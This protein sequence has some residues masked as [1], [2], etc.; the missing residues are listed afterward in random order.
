MILHV[1]NLNI[2]LKGIYNMAKFMPVN[3][4]Q[5]AA[6]NEK[7]S[8]TMFR[9]AADFVNFYNSGLINKNHDDIAKTANEI[10]KTFKNVKDKN[11][12]LV[13]ISEQEV[14]LDEINNNLAEWSLLTKIKREVEQLVSDNEISADSVILFTPDAIGYIV[15]ESADE[16]EYIK[17]NEEKLFHKMSDIVPVYNKYSTIKDAD[18]AAEEVYQFMVYDVTNIDASFINRMHDLLPKN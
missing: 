10:T 8:K 12:K 4:E 16:E 13:F 5:A 7:L 2:T 9:S 3:E 14:F 18:K 11:R 6:L 17:L 15:K 1:C